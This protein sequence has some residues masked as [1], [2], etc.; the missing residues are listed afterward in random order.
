VFLVTGKTTIIGVIGDPIAHSLSPAMHNAAIEALGLD[1]CYVAFRVSSDRVREAVVGV[2]GLNIRG[3]N[4]TVPHKQAVMPFLD[5]VSDEASAIG[6][7]NTIKHE[8]GRL[9]GYN[10]DVYGI[11]AALR[12]GTGLHPLPPE[13][14]VL[15]A[16]G[17]AR[18]IVYALA[19]CEG[20]ERLT[21]LNRTVE[22]AERLAEEM[23]AGAA[24]TG[25]V[26]IEAHSLDPGDVRAALKS[27]GLIIN[28]TSVGMHPQVD[29]TIIDD[30]D[31]FCEGQLLLDTVY[32]PR[33]TRLMAVAQCGGAR[34][35]NGIDMLVYQGA[36]SFEIW[37]GMS[38]PVDVMRGAIEGHPS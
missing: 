9:I 24:S 2:R 10:T 7:V 19:G 15:G 8:D 18:G 34:A 23:L 29:D 17:A 33:Q 20:V 28:A 32:N 13:V 21:I 3:I 6:A 12:Y 35:V 38:P 31:A 5:E 11:R 30:P 4:V 1:W 37:T 14:V 27:A 36:K 26:E 22:K 25:P 16:G